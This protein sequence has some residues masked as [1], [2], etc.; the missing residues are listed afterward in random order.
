MTTTPSESLPPWTHV[1]DFLRDRGADRMPHPGGTLLAHLSRVARLLAAWGADPDVQS[2]GLCHAAY[3]T[4]GFDEALLST[5]ERATLA[6]LVGERAEALVH[7]YGSCDRSAVYPLLGGDAPV[8]FRD[9]FTGDEH[10]PSDADLRAFM[11]ITAA[12]ELDVLAH[13]EDLTARYGAALYGLFARSR[14]LLSPAAW[15]ACT[16]QLG[17]DA[18]A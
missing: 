4:D 6:G 8:V 12:N 10:I 9:R 5:T 1:E 2:A 11:E 17:P 13:N 18:R 7:L 16:R 3:G 15:A 14:D